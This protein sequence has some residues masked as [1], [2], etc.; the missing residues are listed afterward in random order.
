MADRHYALTRRWW[1]GPVSK[2]F[3]LAMLL[4]LPISTAWAGKVLAKSAYLR[5]ID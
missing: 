5:E 4:R 2:L 1:F 3:V